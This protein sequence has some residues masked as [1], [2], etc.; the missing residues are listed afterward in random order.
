MQS[1]SVLAKY[2]DRFTQN[3]C[4]YESWSQYLC[5]VAQAH[6]VRAIVDLACGTGKMTALL[7]TRGYKLIGVDRSQEMLQQA[8][9]KCRALFVQQ[10]V[11]EL[12]LPHPAD[13]AVVV[14][15]G[16]NYLKNDE[17][18]PFFA[19]LS[20]NIRD[21]APLAFD[22]STPYKLRNL[23][24][25]VYFVDDDDATLLW[26]NRLRANALTMDLTLFE[27]VP[28]ATPDSATYLRRDETHTQYMHTRETLSAALAA[29]NF[30][31][32]E[33]S[34]DYGKPYSDTALRHTY[35]AVYK[36]M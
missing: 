10:D 15:D 34:T 5:T 1:Y 21:G 19:N 7:S 31:L 11:R 20:Q 4:D 28:G 23:A 17:L 2:Y 32:V 18:V 25:K 27:R 35:Y 24:D 16:I 13:M 33:V 14:C 8:H 26:T 30:T 29:A 3:D 9:E 6:N 36:G 22:V 12:S